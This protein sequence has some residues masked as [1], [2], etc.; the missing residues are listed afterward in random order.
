MSDRPLAIDLCCGRGGWTAGLL[1]EGW[2]VVGFDVVRPSTFPE[3]GQF[4]QQDVATMT[5]EPWR[6]RVDLVVASPPCTEFSQVWNFARHRQPDPEVAMG[7][8]R[9]CFRI[10]R[11]SGAPFIVENVAGARKYFAAEFGPPSWSVGSFYFWG[12]GPILKPMGRFV[13][14][15]WNTDRDK[16]GNRRWARDN[17]AATYVRDP[18]ERARIP[19][20]IARAVGAQLKPLAV[21]L[22]LA[23][24]ASACAARERCQ[25]LPLPIAWTDGTVTIGTMTMC[26]RGTVSVNPSVFP[27][28]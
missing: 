12:D 28:R 1:A 25:V 9:H 8:V 13:K 17:R 4:V 6:G 3:G 27:L 7:L 5:G 15:I 16:T 22:L 26:S 10:A 23:I 24:G 20:G 18:A 19:I 11:E 2:R 14:G 21:A